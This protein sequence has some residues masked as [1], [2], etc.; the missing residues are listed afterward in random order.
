[1]ARTTLVEEKK[2]GKD[3]D[4]KSE[5]LAARATRKQKEVIQR[6]AH[7]AGRSVTDFLIDSAMAV[8]EK[9]IR[10]QQILELT[11]RETQAFFAAIENP[12]DFDE[13]MREAARWHRENVE[14]RW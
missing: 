2:A 12:P 11:E 7:I 13:K 8:A 14:V 6:A 1:M 10:D 3:E 4:L 5:R 9:T